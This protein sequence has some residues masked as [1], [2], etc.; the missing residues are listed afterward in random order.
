MTNGQCM[1]RKVGGWSVRLHNYIVGRWVADISD[2]SI[3]GDAAKGKGQ[4]G[5]CND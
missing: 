4:C 1:L 3:A 2:K 5:S